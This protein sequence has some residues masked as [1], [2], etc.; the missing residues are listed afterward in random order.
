MVGYSGVKLGQWRRLMP[1]LDDLGF[2]VVVYGFTVTTDP[3][4]IEQIGE[5]MGK[6]DNKISIYNMA[7]QPFDLQMDRHVDRSVMIAVWHR[8]DAAR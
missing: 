4:R 6:Q 2:P 7:A 3:W 5:P 1:M 8:D